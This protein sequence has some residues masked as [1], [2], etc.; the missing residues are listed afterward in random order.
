MGGGS[1]EGRGKRSSERFPLPS[2]EPPPIFFQRLLTGGEAA[3][4]EFG[5]A[6]GKKWG[7][8]GREGGTVQLWEVPP[9]AVPF[10]VECSFCRKRSLPAWGYSKCLNRRFRQGGTFPARVGLFRKAAQTGRGC[11]NFPCPWGFIAERAG[12]N[13]TVWLSP[14]VWALFMSASPRSRLCR[15]FVCN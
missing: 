10:G 2:P 13:Q 7:T 9:P 5:S 8:P 14:L 4:W 11:Q 12:L 15:H 6:E 3:R 1:G